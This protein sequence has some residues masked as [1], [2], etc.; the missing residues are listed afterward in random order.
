VE[1]VRWRV[2]VSEAMSRTSLR[3]INACIQ[4]AVVI[5]IAAAVCTTVV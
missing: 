4:V 5:V 3:A 1:H 2:V